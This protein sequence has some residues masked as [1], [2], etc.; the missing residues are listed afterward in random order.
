MESRYIYLGLLAVTNAVAGLVVRA[1]CLSRASNRR[2]LAEKSQLQR[3]LDLLKKAATE[4]RDEADHSNALIRLL[5]LHVQQRSSE[6]D[7]LRMLLLRRDQEIR[8]LQKDAEGT[9]FSGPVSE[10]GGKTS[11]EMG[12][13]SGSAV[14]QAR[15]APGQERLVLPIS[16]EEQRALLSPAPSSG[17]GSRP[18]GQDEQGAGV[19]VT[20]DWRESLGRMLGV[21]D[22]MEREVRK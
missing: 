6:I 21:L 15:P 14:D 3:D 20:R 22:A 2:L 19:S 12:I 13:S 8:L 11:E 18:A 16:P 4:F 10:Q 7:T 9:A 5:D 1:L 17:S